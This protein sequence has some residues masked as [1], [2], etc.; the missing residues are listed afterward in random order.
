MTER[1]NAEVVTDP[2]ILER[3][4]RLSSGGLDQTQITQLFSNP[5]QIQRL[6]EMNPDQA[7]NV[8]GIISSIAT[9]GSH[10]YLGPMVGEVLAAGLGAMAGAWL[11]KKFLNPGR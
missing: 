2:E 9:Y 1:V 3:L 6:L 8:R 11:S 5:Q 10:R 4:K 7:R